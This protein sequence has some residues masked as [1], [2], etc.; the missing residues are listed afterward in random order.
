METFAV[1]GIIYL[2]MVS[3]ATKILQWAEKKLSYPG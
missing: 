2:F 1:V 3:I